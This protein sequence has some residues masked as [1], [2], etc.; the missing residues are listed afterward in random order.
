MYGAELTEAS[1]REHFE[2][3]GA[4][5][6]VRLIRDKN[7]GLGKGFGYILFEVRAVSRRHAD[8]IHSTRLVVIE[9]VVGLAWRPRPT[10][11]KN[12]P[13]PGAEPRMHLKTSLHTIG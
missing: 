2:G 10:P 5:T 1:L 3:C 8:H 12:S 6:A 4:V 11:R 9:L 13:T 7:T